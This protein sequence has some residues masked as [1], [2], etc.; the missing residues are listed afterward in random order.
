MGWKGAVRSIGAA[1]RAAERDAKRRQRELERQQKQYEK[2]QE[3]EQASYEVEVYQNHIDLI[4]SVHKECGGS[5][6]W[7]EVASATKPE[8]PENNREREKEAKA[9]EA[10]YR[11]RFI[12]RTFKREKKKRERL[13]DGVSKSIVDDKLD[14]EAKVKF[15]ENE[16][17]D[18]SESVPLAHAVLKGD[19]NSKLTA[20]EKLDPFSEISTL[21]SS[22]KFNIAE[23]SVIEATI[24]IHGVDIVPGEVKSLLKSGRLSLKKMPKGQFNEFHQDYVCSCVLRIARELFSILP[25]E[26]VYVTAVDQLLNSKTGHTE[27]TPILSVAISRGTLKSLNMDSIDPS[28]SMSNFVHNM[29]FKKTKGFG[30]VARLIP[31]SL[32][33]I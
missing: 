22:L 14:Y 23:N 15:W 6:D 21:G 19:A 13:A 27:E 18:W 20:I 8:K 24:N 3:L 4:K 28:D 29:S 17:R 31:E 12:D 30:P 10:S 33:N 16:C 5:V 1:A 25:D 26:I 7:N 2:M 32:Q 11:P 9:V